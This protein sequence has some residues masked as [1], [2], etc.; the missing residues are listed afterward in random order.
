MSLLLGGKEV[1]GR[2]PGVGDAVSGICDGEGRGLG[3][4]KRDER[5]SVFCFQNEVGVITRK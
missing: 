3:C 5:C 2:D 1:R 4:R